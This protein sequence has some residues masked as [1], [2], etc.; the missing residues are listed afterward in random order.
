MKKK[1]LLLRSSI[2]ILVLNSLGFRKSSHSSEMQI[3][4]LMHREG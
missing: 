2:E 1:W 3:N 4:A